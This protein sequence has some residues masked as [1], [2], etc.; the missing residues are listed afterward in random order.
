M[1]NKIVSWCM[2][3]ILVGRILVGSIGYHLIEIQKIF[4]TMASF[5]FFF[6]T[7]IIKNDI[8]E[9]DINFG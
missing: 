3:S 6:W 5:V 7:L 1:S 4:E 2:G 9:E 8:L